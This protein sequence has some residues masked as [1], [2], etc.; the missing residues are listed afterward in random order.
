[1]SRPCL[2]PWRHAPC[3]LEGM[4]VIYPRLGW[5]G[6]DLRCGAVSSLKAH[7]CHLDAP[8]PT[9][10]G[11][12]RRRFVATHGRR[13]SHGLAA[14]LRT[15]MLQPARPPAGPLRRRRL[16]IV[17]RVLHFFS[18]FFIQAVHAFLLGTHSYWS[19]CVRMHEPHPHA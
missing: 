4:H 14:V 16:G 13:V 5:N 19:G 1:M 15:Y 12:D 7:S 11:V 3:G 2:G 9:G 10:A 6:R 8:H 17:L 18:C